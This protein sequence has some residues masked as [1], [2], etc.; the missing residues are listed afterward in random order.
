MPTLRAGWPQEKCSLERESRPLV[1]KEGHRVPDKKQQL[2]TQK[3][4][5]CRADAE[6][7]GA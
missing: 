3:G 6:V 1:L 2:H 7:A 5:A 4:W